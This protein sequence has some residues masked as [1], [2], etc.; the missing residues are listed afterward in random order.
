MKP[1]SNNTDTTA[2]RIESSNQSTLTNVPEYK[3]VDT[4]LEEDTQLVDEFIKNPENKKKAGE[5][6]FQIQ[7]D[8]PNWF[9]VPQIVKKYKTST[10]EASKKIEM[11]MLFKVCVGKVEKNQPLFKIDLTQKVQRNL[12][13]EEIAQKEGEIL[14][15][16]EKLSSLD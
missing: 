1:V 6:A 8:F 15:L 10:I 14:F 13:L 12:I 16:K 5:I 2:V 9:R 3:P 7:Q 11:L 4:T